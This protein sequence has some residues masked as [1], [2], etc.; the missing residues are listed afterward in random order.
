VCPE[1]LQAGVHREDLGAAVQRVM[2]A[3]VAAEPVCGEQLRG[4]LTAAE[5]VHVA[6]GGWVPSA[7]MVRI[8]VGMPRQRARAASTAALPVSA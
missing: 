8:S 1:Y 2:E 3:P 5:Q 4:V 7:W 6:P